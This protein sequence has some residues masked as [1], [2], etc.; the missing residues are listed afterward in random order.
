M[1]S[2]IFKEILFGKKH[3][4]GAGTMLSLLKNK[5]IVYLT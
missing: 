1:I 3:I 5:K 2:V 4:F